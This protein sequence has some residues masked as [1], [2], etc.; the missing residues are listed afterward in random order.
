MSHTTAVDRALIVISFK[1]RLAY[2]SGWVFGLALGGGAMLISMAM[3]H[4]L[5]GT[6]SL[7]GYDWES[8]RAYLII[9]FIAATMVFGASDFTIA[10]RILDGHIAV[11]MTKPVDFQ[12]ARGAE[13]IG[14]MI[15]T[16]PTAAVGVLG[17]WLLFDPPGPATPVAGV[18][19]AVSFLLLFPLAFGITYLSILVCFWTKRYLGIMWLREALLS[20]FSG[21]MIPLAFM[22]G[23]LQAVSWALPFPHFT[24]TPAA[25]YLGQVDVPG[26]LGLIAA[27]A[28][29]VVGLWFAGRLVFRF[30]VRKVTVHGG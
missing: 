3:W 25:I 21:M 27:E 10:D 18:L 2:K 17:A 6:G 5:L 11:D 26:A 15:S 9:G 1:R 28:A 22:P 30:A 19:T 8:M 23:W 16:A 12:R 29:W 13:Y 4:N 7:S 14:S 24:A 20:F